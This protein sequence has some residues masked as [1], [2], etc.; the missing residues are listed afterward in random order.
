MYFSRRFDLFLDP[1]RNARLLKGRFCLSPLYTTPNDS[2]DTIAPRK[3]LS[4][5]VARPIV[6]PLNAENAINIV[7]PLANAGTQTNYITSLRLATA[8]LKQRHMLYAPV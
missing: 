5:R 6:A 4:L 8:H 3:M 2:A 7:F 1:L